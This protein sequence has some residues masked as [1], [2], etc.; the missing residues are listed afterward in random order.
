MTIIKAV[1][2]YAASST[3]LHSDYLDAAYLLGC[4]LAQHGIKCIYG[5]GSVGLMGRLADGVLDNKGHLVGVI[6]KFMMEL[7]WG[8]PNATEMIVVESMSQRKELLIKEADAVIVLP[9]GTGT[10]EELAE[11]LSAK[12]LGL[13]RLPLIFINTRNFFDP[14]LQFFDVM[15]Q[16]EFMHHHHKNMW[17]VIQ[18]PHQIF[19]AIKNSDNWKDADAYRS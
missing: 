2:V 4:I 16:E 10:L 9:G 19:E 11:V 17:Q 8:N 12:K 14:L 3:K 15:I 7:E 18:D 5:G 1:C 13:N 6:P